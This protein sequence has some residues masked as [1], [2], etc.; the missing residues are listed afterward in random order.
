MITPSSISRHLRAVVLLVLGMLIMLPADISGGLTDQFTQSALAAKKK[1][2]KKKT[3]KP[4]KTRR[5][6]SKKKTRKS[7]KRRMAKKRRTRKARPAVT[8]LYASPDGRE[9]IHRGKRGIIISRDTAGTVRGMAPLTSNVNGGA[10]YATAI[11]RYADV[12]AGDSVRIYMLIAPSQGEYYMPDR[13]GGRGTEARAI[14][15]TASMLRKS[16]TPIFVD[17]TL[18]R[19]TGEEIYSRTDHHWSPRGGRYAASALAEAAGLPFLPLSHYR[20]DT[21]R[22]YV[23]TMF[24]FSGDPALS[25]APENFVW[26]EPIDKSYTA[27]FVDYRISGGRNVGESEPHEAPFFRPFPDGSRAAYCTFMGGDYFAVK[28]KKLKGDPKRRLLI[29]KDSFGNALPSN[30][31]GTFGEV[32][33]LDFRYYP[34]NLVRYVRDNGITD[35]AFVNC[36]SIAFAP[37]TARRLGTMLTT[38][39]TDFGSTGDTTPPVPEEEADED[40]EEDGTE[41]STEGEE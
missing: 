25:N 7:R 5:S 23:G 14:R 17:D 13:I 6:K 9:F 36:I 12:L 33:V 8:T 24:M 40:S 2:K 10:A 37:N 20:A 11:N 19:H 32:H 30:L 28:V 31:F 16:V 4:K 29:V 18:R 1:K 22:N 39:G 38:A 35:L 34:H 21:V 27:T 26:F 41:E 3:R 15:N